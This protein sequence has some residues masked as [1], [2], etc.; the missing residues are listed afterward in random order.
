M[1][2]LSAER[3][4]TKW[5]LKQP[6]NRREHESRAS[7]Q[8]E[9]N[10]AQPDSRYTGTN[11]KSCKVE[12]SAALAAAQQRSLQLILLLI[13]IAVCLLL[14]LSLLQLPRLSGAA[15]GNELEQ[16]ALAAVSIVR[17]DCGAER[18]EGTSGWD[19]S[20]R[21]AKQAS[22]ATATQLVI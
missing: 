9:G 19:G 3:L 8:G 12:G 1:H 4:K 13:I 7:K 18:R 17:V 6:Q 2:R 14:V 20:A 15:V 22:R 16:V 5:P 21:W 11:E 10:R